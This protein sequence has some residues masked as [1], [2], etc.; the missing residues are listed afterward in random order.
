LAVDLSVD[1]CGVRLKNPVLMASGILGVGRG[2]LLRIAREGAGG[3]V[4]KSCCLEPRTGHPNPTVLDY[5]WGV[6]NAV[7]LSNPGVEAEIEELRGIR[8]ELVPTRTAFVA[9]MFEATVE[10]FGEVACRL[11]EL[12]PDLIEVNISCPNTESDLGRMFA[13]EPHSAAAVVREIKRR[14][15]VPIIM[16][17]SPNVTDIA[18]IARACEAEGADALAC[19]NTV[20]PGMF[21]DLETGRPILANQVGGL[22]GPAFKPI[23]VAK[24]YEVSRAV[25]IPVVAVGGVMTGADVI[26]MVMAGA[27]CVGI[28][29][30]AYYRGPEVYGLVV[31]ETAAWLEERG[32]GSLAEIQGLAHREPILRG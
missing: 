12:E 1:L 23:T 22:S 14:V 10:G 25:Q 16:K 2:L 24:V 18:E 6:T 30:A 17:L 15:S 32:H 26:E 7:G 29:T 8:A 3:V 20:G 21:I 4:P 28:G 9:S 5:G 11:Q 19:C 27:R 31:A 13:A